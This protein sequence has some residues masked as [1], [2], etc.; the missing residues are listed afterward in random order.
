M[1]TLHSWRHL[2]TFAKNDEEA[3]TDELVI[4]EDLSTLSLEK[5]RELR[6]RVAET[7]AD[8]YGDGEADYSA[9]DLGTL[10]K[11]AE[12]VEALDAELEERDK[13][14]A[15][16]RAAADELAAKVKKDEEGEEEPDDG[17]EDSDDEADE[18][19]VEETPA[20]EEEADEEEFSD[21]KRGEFRVNLASVK[22]KKVA[23]KKAEKPATTV[24]FANRNTGGY[25]AGDAITM[26]GVVDLLGDTLGRYRHGVY[27]NAAQRGQA[28]SERHTLAMLKKPADKNATLTAQDSSDR[29]ADVLAHVTNEKQTPQGSLVASG[30]W[31]G[32]SETLFD[33]VPNLPSTDGI[34]SVPEFTVNSGGVNYTL[35][36]DYRAVYAT[37]FQYTEEQDKAGQYGVDDNGVGNDTEGSKPCYRVPCPEFNEVR[38]GITGLCITS[39]ILQARSFRRA[40]EET[41]QASLIAH[42]HR[43]A[44]QIAETIEKESDAVS[45]PAEQVGTAAPVLT[46]IEL[47]VMHFRYVNRLAFNA[48]LEAKF[49][50]WVLGALR[51]D[52]AR[53]LGVDMISVPDTRIIAWFRERG[54]VPEFIYNWQDLTGKASDFT[55]WPTEVKFLLYQAGT[56]AKGSSDIITLDNVFDSTLLGTNDFTALFTEE[57]WLLLQ[58]RRDSR[59]ITVPIAATG[60]THG[61]VLINHDGTAAGDGA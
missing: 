60:A 39:G 18:D 35:G 5:A 30:G 34:I 57:A 29:V 22:R 51:A 16:R 14:A 28:L 44:K 27:A 2:A 46:A 23:P 36:P 12:G 38:L 48:T 61:G 49:P 19:S 58:R 8:I 21:S 55:K 7:F 4:P 6:T 50:Y 59:V 32:P 54:V 40:L 33:Y 10:A 43:V 56:W 26:D 25:H 37:G 17:D 9:E 3:A 15:E 42:R 52:L 45:L 53:R 1:K 20:D 31:C 24:L 11:L 41:V 47:Q 13:A